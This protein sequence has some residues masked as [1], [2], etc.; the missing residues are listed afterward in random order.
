MYKFGVF[1]VVVL[2]FA[3]SANG[4]AGRK[5]KP[6][7]T[8]VVERPAE[9]TYSESKPNPT[10]RTIYTPRFPGTSVGSRPQTDGLKTASTPIEED[11]IKVETELITIPVSVFDRNGLYIPNLAKDN[12]KIFENGVEQE[13]EYF[14][15]DDKPFTVILLLDTSLSTEYKIGEIQ[16]AAKAFVDNLQP[17]DSVMVIE[18][19]GNVHVLAEAT[20]DREKIYKAIRKADFGSGTSL[21]DAVEFSIKKRLSKVQGRKAIVLFTDGVDTTSSKANYDLTVDLAEEADCLIFPIYYN[22]FFQQPRNTGGIR[23]PGQGGVP[24]RDPRGQSA[25]EYEIGRRYLDELAMYTGGRVFRPESTLGG[26]RRAF[27]GIAEELRRQ[28]NIG[29]VPKETGKPGQRKQIRVRVD[30]PNLVLRARDSY[31]VGAVNNS[32]VPAN[33][34]P[35]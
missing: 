17:Q 9:A 10:R 7:P 8:P 3:I 20:N 19:D 23:F 18:F 14:G 11:I 26:L 5:I 2:A 24:T 1:A 15:T 13:I 31:I 28:Y 6:T 12:F 35:K 22:T 32:A 33:T 25:E 30:R 4:Q 27:E 16:E 29:Y 21:Y 34:K